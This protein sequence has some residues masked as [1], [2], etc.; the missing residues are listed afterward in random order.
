MS[1]E[2]GNCQEF[3]KSHQVF[4]CECKDSNDCLFVC[5]FFCF[6]KLRDLP[7]INLQKVQLF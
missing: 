1:F 2:V 3:R 7:E 5:V 4:E 6:D